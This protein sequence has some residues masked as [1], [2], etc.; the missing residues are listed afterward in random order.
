MCWRFGEQVWIEQLKSSPPKITRP[1]NIA[2]QYL[3]NSWLFPSYVLLL[4]C[5]VWPHIVLTC[6]SQSSSYSTLYNSQHCKTLAIQRAVLQKTS[7][8]NFTRLFYEQKVGTV[9]GNILQCSLRGKTVFYRLGAG[10]FC[11]NSLYSDSDIAVQCSG[12]EPKAGA[13]LFWIKYIFFSFLHNPLRS[14]CVVLL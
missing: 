12:Q 14:N 9:S 4:V 2:N 1:P 11:C 8:V 10:S 5:S 3:W 7:T 6:H 13:D